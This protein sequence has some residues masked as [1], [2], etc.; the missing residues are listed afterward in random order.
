GYGPAATSMY[1]QVDED[2]YPDEEEPERRGMSWGALVAAALAIL[3]VAAV[4]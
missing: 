1:D 4:I 3:A 2:Y